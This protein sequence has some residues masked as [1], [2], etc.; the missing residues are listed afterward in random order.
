MRRS[1]HC[2]WPSASDASRSTTAGRVSHALTA[3]ACSPT[4][5]P[6]PRFSTAGNQLGS[7]AS[8]ARS[9]SV[10][11]SPSM[12]GV[13]ASKR[14]KP[15]S[16]STS[17][18]RCSWMTGSI[19]R[20]KPCDA[21]RTREAAGRGSWDRPGRPRRSPLA[22]QAARRVSAGGAADAVKASIARVAGAVARPGSH[23][24]VRTLVVYGSSGRR[25]CGPRRRPV[26]DLGLSP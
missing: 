20:T 18:N 5:R 19:P 4:K 10:S 16:A 13:I 21:T 15:A 8:A 7:S 25:V 1:A 24:T 26:C 6:S 17:R 3:A 14:V 11:Y 2:R 9:T 23:R 12:S 22:P